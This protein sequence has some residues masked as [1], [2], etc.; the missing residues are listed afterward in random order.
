MKNS[1]KIYCLAMLFFLCASI[2]SARQSDIIHEDEVP[3]NIQ[4][5]FYSTYKNAT[6]AQ[7]S[8][9]ENLG[10]KSMKVTFNINDLE[11]AVVYDMSGNLMEEISILKKEKSEYLINSKIIE[12]YPD[13]KVLTIKRV[14]K[15]N[16]QG[17]SKPKSYYEVSAKNGKNIVYVFFDEDKQLLKTDN[18]FNLAVN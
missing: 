11:K 8:T 18:I 9:V 16:I 15:F 13:S 4:G 5:Y 3:L 2:V 6:D 17:I 12:K 14:T 7:W 1:S 10:E